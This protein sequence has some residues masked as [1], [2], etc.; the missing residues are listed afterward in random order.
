MTALIYYTTPDEAIVAMDTVTKTEEPAYLSK[1]VYLPH[2]R[3]IVA[4]TGIGN[5]LWDWLLAMSHHAHDVTG[6]EALAEDA[7][8]ELKRIY[9]TY[10]DHV[11]TTSTIYHFG[12]SEHSGEMV[13]HR[14]HSGEEF[15]L[16]RL[17]HE[18]MFLKP[19]LDQVPAAKDSLDAN[20][21]MLLRAQKA[22]E[23]QKDPDQRCYIGGEGVLIRLTRDGAVTRTLFEFD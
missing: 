12:F 22:Q 11:K 10:S 13:G 14:F 17:P 20:V 7:P 16:D 19:P 18:V 5:L 8:E 23:D 21:E 3:T 4:I 2:I 6:I 15:A 9:E 1:F